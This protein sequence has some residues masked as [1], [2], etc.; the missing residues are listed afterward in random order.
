MNPF[1]LS[2]H[3]KLCIKNLKS[4]RVICCSQCP[5]EEDILAYYPNL[6]GL[7]EAKRK[8]HNVKAR[9]CDRLRSGW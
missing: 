2:N 7:F 6:R 9:K 3:V 4:K 1:L 8:E 5:F